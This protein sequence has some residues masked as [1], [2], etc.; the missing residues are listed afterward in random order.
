MI[1]IRPATAADCADLAILDDIAGHG[2]TSEAWARAAAAGQGASALEV[3]RESY[4]GEATPCNW[5]NARVAMSDDRAA[6]MSVGYYLPETTNFTGPFDPVFEPVISLF[7]KAVGG[8]LLDALAVYSVFRGKGI[9]R[10]LLDDQM[11]LAG[12]RP[13][14]IVCADDNAPALGLYRSRGFDVVERADFVQT[15]TP[16]DTKEWLLLKRPGS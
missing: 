2:L 6:G 9:A 8:W 10:T 5:R 7:K 14:H 12:D 1:E 4:L 13:F 16:R 11:A 3:G 15:E